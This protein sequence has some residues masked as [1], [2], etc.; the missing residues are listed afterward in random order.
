MSLSSD[1]AAESLKEIDRTRQRSAQA[2]RYANSSPFFILWGVIW[3][4]G[5][6]A[7]D[8][9][10]HHANPL[11]LALM[12]AGLLGHMAIGRHRASIGEP[13]AG[14]NRF[15]GLRLLAGFIAVFCF[16]G[17]SYAIFAPVGWKQ[18]ASFVPLLMALFYVLVGLWAGT[19][20]VVTGLAVAALTLGGF[21]Y[22]PTHFLLW[23]AL[24]GGGALILAGLWM[25]KI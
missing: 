19:R 25:R 22:L 20:F 5:Y 12:A 7:T 13:H 17:A 15:A 21:F 23:M 11:W 9:Y 18:Q 24:V 14:M 2:Y 16:V 8:L 3:M 10:P 4:V 6:T 1:Q